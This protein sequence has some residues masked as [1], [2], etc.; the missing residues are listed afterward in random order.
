M[1]TVHCD[2]AN[3]PPSYVSEG[4]YCSV[5]RNGD[6]VIIREKGSDKPGEKEP[7]LSVHS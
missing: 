2:H 1:P 5:K 3:S 4:F 7:L 6:K